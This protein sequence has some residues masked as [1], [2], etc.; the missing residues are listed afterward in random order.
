MRKRSNRLALFGTAALLAVSAFAAPGHAASASP[1]APA[2]PAARDYMKC[3][4]SIHSGPP[5]Y[6]DWYYNCTWADA[7][8]TIKWKDGHVSWMCTASGRAYRLADRYT[9]ES[10]WISAQC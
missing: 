7:Q 4:F 1:A 5:Q 10:A 6:G 8:I 2:E 9:V 3:G